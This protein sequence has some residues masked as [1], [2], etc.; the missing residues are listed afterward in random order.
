MPDQ[1]TKKAWYSKTN[2]LGALQIAAGMI[3][4]LAGSD[5]IQQ[6]PRAVAAVAVVSGAVT[7]V[8]RT[9]TSVPVEW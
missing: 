2:L 6:Y 3:G 7:I 9:I 1:K 5:L 4:V 8:L